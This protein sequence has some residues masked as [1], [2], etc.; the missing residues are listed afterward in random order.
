MKNLRKSPPQQAAGEK[1]EKLT[2]ILGKNHKYC[3]K[4]YENTFWIWGKKIR[5]HPF[6]SKST[7]ILFG[8]DPQKD[9]P[10]TIYVAYF[11]DSPLA[12]CFGM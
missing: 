7:K 4:N 8:F 3:V 5:T 12:S 6:L 1:F 2:I 9:P 11:L 10:T